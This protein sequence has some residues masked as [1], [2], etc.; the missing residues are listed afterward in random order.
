MLPPCSL[1]AE[2]TAIKDKNRL[3][4]N[5]GTAVCYFS[6]ILKSGLS[7]IVAKASETSDCMNNQDMFNSGLSGYH[8]AC[9]LSGEV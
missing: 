1:I 7:F 4:W 8:R 5:M 6:A 3:V 9:Y 2:T